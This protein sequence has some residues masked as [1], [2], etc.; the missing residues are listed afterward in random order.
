MDC[1]VHFDTNKL[2]M[3]DHLLKVNKFL[4]SMQ[5][6]EW[7]FSDLFQTERDFEYAIDIDQRYQ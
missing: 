3:L 4:L 2:P 7:R 5:G 6:F 1:V